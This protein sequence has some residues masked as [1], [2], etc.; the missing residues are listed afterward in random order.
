MNLQEDLFGQFVRRVMTEVPNSDR[1]TI[2]Y[3]KA[4]INQHRD[5]TIKVEDRWSEKKL[6]MVEDQANKYRN[7]VLLKNLEELDLE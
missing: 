5:K 3:L 6:K 7:D 2:Y 1:I 4:I